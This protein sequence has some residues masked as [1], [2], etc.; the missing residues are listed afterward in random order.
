MNTA[1]IIPAAL[2]L[3]GLAVRTAYEITKKR[4]KLDP[5]NPIIFAVVFA[6]MVLM[7]GSWAF[8]APSDPSRIAVPAAVEWFGLALLALGLALA[9]AGVIK[10]K[11]L[12]NIDHL[13]TTGLYAKLRHPMYTGFI[14]WIAG[15]V[16]RCGAAAGAAV[17]LIAVGHILYWRWLEEQKLI[18]E[19]GETYR[20][21]MKR[22][23]F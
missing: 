2:C 22:S 12:E 10:L 17:G 3:I 19:Y 11:G 18:A 21:Y 13:A 6:G 14:L 23:W 15:W 8:L 7:L 20:G 16:I 1:F 9:L 4:G 5:K